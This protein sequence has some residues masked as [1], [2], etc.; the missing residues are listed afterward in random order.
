[1]IVNSSAMQ[2]EAREHMREGD[3]TVFVTDLGGCQTMPHCRMASR[4]EIPAGASIGY[5]VHERET[6]L[7]AILE[8]R[9]V[10]TERDGDHPVGPGD[11]V[12]TA[13]GEGHSIKN[14]GDKPLVMLAVITTEA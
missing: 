14:V 7:Y 3:G 13:H 6:E 5:H 10:V 2:T 8:G 11:A 1:M 4:I 12:F 9:G